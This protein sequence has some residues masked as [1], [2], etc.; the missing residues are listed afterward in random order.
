MPFSSPLDTTA[1]QLA[2]A[3]GIGL[4]IGAERERRKGHGAKRAPAGVRTF[5]I[6]ALLGAVAAKL[7]G[8]WLL[9]ALILGLSAMLAIAYWRSRQADPGLTTECALVLTL[10]LGALCIRTPI[11]ASAI[12]VIVA[13]LLA[14]RTYLHSL[15][16]ISLSE[17][18][19]NDT[20]VM[21]A[22][23]L[24]ILPLMPDR[25]LGPFNAFN[26]RIVWK[27]VVLI[28]TIGTIGHYALRVAGPRIGLPLA[29]LISGFVSSAATISTMGVRAKQ[30]PVLLHAAV[31][32]ALFSTIATMVQ[33]ALLL[34]A[35]S[36]PVLVAMALPLGLGCAMA[37]AC[38]LFF[39]YSAH[40]QPLPERLEPDRS[41]HLK[42]SLGL[43]VIIVA[44]LFVSAALN[45]W[46]GRNGVLVATT[47]GG[48]A[49]AHS[50]SASVA[51]LVEAGKLDARA[52]AVPIMLSLT[53]NS[54]TKVILAYTNGSRAFASLVIPGLCLVIG[55]AWLGWALS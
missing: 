31:T 18:E 35:I 41:F 10:L 50:S 37:I 9:P 29:G 32:G 45:D 25:Y 21:A 26:P 23:A 15:V 54:L 20:L 47:I 48:L 39:A 40:K 33:M 17:Q 55:A 51:S 53:S 28:M 38:G 22:A 30:H 3:L 44:I 27:F 24:V 52:A 36:R 16:T 5:S 12:A 49:D 4:L 2:A 34:G 46:L 7:G 13:I 14:S 19:L 43:T 8:D 11:L 42:T 1:F 6:V